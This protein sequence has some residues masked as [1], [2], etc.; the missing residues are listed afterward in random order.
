MIE[1]TDL[2]LLLPLALPVVLIFTVW[3][4]IKERR[5]ARK[6][7]IAEEQ[8][9][10]ADTARRVAEN[11]KREAETARRV[12]EGEREF[13]R[14][15]RRLAVAAKERAI[16]DRERATAARELARAEEKKA[17]EDRA[18]ATS[19]YEDLSNQMHRVAE[20]EARI[21]HDVPKH[22][23]GLRKFI[24][25]KFEKN[26]ERECALGELDIAVEKVRLHLASDIVQH[27]EEECTSGTGRETNGLS[28]AALV[29]WIAKML[30]CEHRL[31]VKG[32]ERICML[33]KRV[34]WDLM[35][36][37]ILSNAFFHSRPAGQVV[38]TI[39]L[40]EDGFGKVSIFNEGNPISKADAKLVFN[41]G[42]SSKRGGRGLG[43]YVAQ[44]IA[45][46]FKAE[47]LPPESRTGWLG[48][49]RGVEFTIINLP[50][51]P[52]EA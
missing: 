8:K 12:A 44:E 10:A 16:E 35:L 37:N 18:I 30:E 29:R 26:V 39:S 9:D 24:E 41:L 52:P 6:L 51:V 36:T 27:V 38:V 15:E 45:K 19:R 48:G 33:Y 17:S 5:V 21:Q 42:Q 50:V 47:I 22:L 49:K 7:V 2:L 11:E 25:A 32:D 46:G 14:E 40:Q 13:A 4:W 28:I 31:I 3:L 23:D 1:L 20:L 34:F 43:L